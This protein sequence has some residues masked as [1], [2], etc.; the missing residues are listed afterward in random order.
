M[1]YLAALLL[2]LTA[3]GCGGGT[4]VV[5]TGSTAATNPK[6]DAGQL[7]GWRQTIAH[8]P[9][10][11][12]ACFVAEYPATV[13]TK[14]PCGEPPKTLFLPDGVIHVGQAY[15]NAAQSFSQSPITSAYGS[16]DS[17]TGVESVCSV[18]CPNTPAQNNLCP[19]T[20]TC[21]S[22]KDLPNNFSLQLNT[23]TF[24]T[25]VFK[26]NAN[27]KWMCSGWQQFLFS[28]QNCPGQGQ[29][30]VLI[31]YWLFNYDNGNG[32][33]S[34]KWQ[35]GPNHACII[36]SHSVTFPSLDVGLLGSMQL[37]GVASA[38]QTDWVFF[39]VGTTA[40]SGPGDDYFPEL[41]QQWTQ[42]EFNIF[43][44]G[45]GTQAVL[46]PGSTLVLRVVVDSGTPGAPTCIAAGATTG[47]SNNL[48]LIGLPAG[49]QD[50]PNSGPTRT[51]SGPLQKGTPVPTGPSNTQQGNVF[52]RPSSAPGPA[53]VFSETN[54]PDANYVPGLI[55]CYG[56][57]TV[58]TH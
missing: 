22:G 6:P 51:Y 17:V 58:G 50:A 9:R 53:L 23:N 27:P 11:E 37:M 10:P 21:T 56:V 52:G 15:D 29:A 5:S 48:A 4:N 2:T 39:A 47:E 40:Y 34:S 16:F 13:W 54:A 25:S 57:F 45:S 55:Q 8:T 31:Q 3:A 28:N 43:G 41:A 12:K 35:S 26:C 24:A 19:T 18:Q 49:P 42:A 32:C 38:F 46:N 20:Y 1:R 36:N 7:K 33:P 44:N 30:C 14:V